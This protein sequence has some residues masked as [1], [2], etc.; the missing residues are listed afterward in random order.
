MLWR[1][2]G[3]ATSTAASRAVPFGDTPE[4]SPSPVTYQSYDSDLLPILPTHFVAPS[5]GPREVP[6][7]AMNPPSVTAAEPQFQTLEEIDAYYATIA[8]QGTAAVPSLLNARFSSEVP[9]EG[10]EGLWKLPRNS[11]SYYPI[12]TPVKSMS[13]IEHD[14]DRDSFGQV[15]ADGGAV[16]G[17]AGNVVNDIEN[18]DEVWI[19]EASSV[20]AQDT[21][22]G[23]PH[24]AAT[25]AAALVY[26]SFSTQ[27]SVLAAPQEGSYQLWAASVRDSPQEGS[28]QLR[29]WIDKP[30][31]EFDQWNGFEYVEKENDCC[32]TGSESRQDAAMD[33]SYL[34]FKQSVSETTAKVSIELKDEQ[35][36]DE[37]KES[38]KLAHADAKKGEFPEMADSS[39][40]DSGDERAYRDFERLRA[41]RRKNKP[42]VIPS[43][44]SYLEGVPHFT[45]LTAR[46]PYP[47]G[48]AGQPPGDAGAAV[49]TRPMGNTS[50]LMARAPYRDLKG[51]FLPPRDAGAAISTRQMGNTH[52]QTS[53]TAGST[54]NL[55]TCAD[56]DRLGDRN[57]HEDAFEQTPLS[58]PYSSASRS[59]ASAR[60]ERWRSRKTRSRLDMATGQTTRCHPR[61]AKEFEDFTIGELKDIVETCSEKISVK[62]G[63][64]FENFSRELPEVEDLAWM[65]DIHLLDDEEPE[66]PTEDLLNLNWRS[67]MEE[68]GGRKFVRVES[69]MDSGAST[70]VAPPSM[71]PGMPVKPS[72]GSRRGQKWSSASKHKIRNLGE[73][74]L[75]AVTEEGEE[76]EVLF[77]I[78]DVSKPLVSVSAICERGNRVIFGRSGGV[79]QSLSTGKLIPFERRNGIYILSLWLE[80]ESEAPFRR[81]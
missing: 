78:A 27:N 59:S 6:Q 52:F 75:K 3:F 69:V 51:Q 50:S 32:W 71:M 14:R 28:N 64:G 31:E 62:Q 19:P 56:E 72:E 22:E 21:E 8:S 41:A 76:T 61:V 12:S 65:D 35:M 58:K 4:E 37:E 18:D 20:L 1:D 80:D 25:G 13:P 42:R 23:V 16:G 53:A 9:A 10:L 54:G 57:N 48:M 36:Q 34:Q 49:S 7:E 60:R 5:T 74:R 39:D 55:P 38:I 29:T 24:P 45:S 67:D 44:E 47:E 11:P 46:A 15:D 68:F 81:P 40:D 17:Q 73:Q 2:E 43:P 33:D 26:T 66:K 70:P 79:V 30:C 77:Q 63:S